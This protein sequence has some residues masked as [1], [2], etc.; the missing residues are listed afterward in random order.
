MINE[1][2]AFD[3]FMDESHDG[4]YCVAGFLGQVGNWNRLWARWTKM[5]EE[6]DI[7]AFHMTDCE[8]AYHDFEG[9]SREDRDAIQRKAIGIV[10]AP[11]VRIVGIAT[12]VHV[13]PY[14][15]VRAELEK[16]R[17]FLPGQPGSGSIGDPYFLAFQRAVEAVCG[18]TIVGLPSTE[19]IGFTFDRNDELGGRALQLYALLADS[20]NLPYAKRLGQIAFQDKRT[21][22]PLQAAD[23]LVYEA[24]RY[25][26]EVRLGGKPERWQWKMLRPNVPIVHWFGET[27]LLLLVEGTRR[28]AEERMRAQSPPTT[29]PDDDA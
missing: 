21:M 6:T 4:V 17:R 10:N 2:N 11:D 29:S 8:G 28:L 12:G 13:E 18:V 16:Y 1:A 20:P 26:L 14:A 19:R 27:E 3:A 24:Y 23:L 9:W 22:V 25:L 7:P 5:L 15:R